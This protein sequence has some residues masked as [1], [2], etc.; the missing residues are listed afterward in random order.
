[1][2]RRRNGA[3]ACPIVLTFGNRR[4]ATSPRRS[5]SQRPCRIASRRLGNPSGRGLWPHEVDLL[6]RHAFVA[7]DCVRERQVKEEVG[8]RELDQEAIAAKGL[9]TT[10]PWKLDR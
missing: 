7:E 6:Q 8:E 5:G 1:M 10:A 9:R 4:T 2:S 3:C